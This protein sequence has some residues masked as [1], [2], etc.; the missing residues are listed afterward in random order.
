MDRLSSARASVAPDAAPACVASPQLGGMK[1]DRVRWFAVVSP[2]GESDYPIC[3][4]A[5]PIGRAPRLFPTPSGPDASARGPWR[6]TGP[7]LLSRHVWSVLGP[8]FHKLT[9]F[10]AASLV[11]LQVVGLSVRRVGH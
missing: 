8:E 3:V 7:V 5:R 10:L 4:G 11:S 9:S 1:I 2:Y 6:D